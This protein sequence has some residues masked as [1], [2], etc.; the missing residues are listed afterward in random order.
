[1]HE[2]TCVGDIKYLLANIAVN[3]WNALESVMIIFSSY[4]IDDAYDMNDKNGRCNG[5]RCIHCAFAIALNPS[6]V[7][8]VSGISRNTRFNVPAIVLMSLASSRLIATSPIHC[9]ITIIR[10]NH[11]Y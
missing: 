11:M 8:N 3:S 9:L 10:V 6:S 1:M 2:H 5:D 4:I 7:N